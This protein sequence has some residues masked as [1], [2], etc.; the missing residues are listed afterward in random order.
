V[1]AGGAIDIRNRA[2]GQA[3]VIVDVW[4]YFEP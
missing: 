4:G 2:G 1:S 3:D